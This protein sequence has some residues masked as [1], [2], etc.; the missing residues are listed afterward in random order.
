MAEKVNTE[1]ETTPN[2]GG[3]VEDYCDAYCDR[4]VFSEFL[5][6]ASSSAWARWIYQGRPFLDISGEKMYG[7]GFCHVKNFFAMVLREISRTRME[8]ANPMASGPFTDNE[9]ETW[10]S[11]MANLTMEMV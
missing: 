1:R 4:K 11:L 10:S 3:M 2:V 6:Y 5:K 7:H 9:V 8:S